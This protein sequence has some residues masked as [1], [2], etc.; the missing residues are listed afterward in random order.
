MNG[1]QSDSKQHVVLI[2]EDEDSN[3]KYLEIV[4]KKAM[5]KVLRAN[6]GI[7]AVEKCRTHPE[8]DILLLDL[9][10]P[11]MDG[12]EAAKR[13]RNILPHLPVIALSAYVSS[14]D[15]EAAM[16]AGCTEYV[17]KPISKTRLLETIT[18]LLRK[19]N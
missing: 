4:L 13:I 9:K 10:M 16:Q 11:G 3:F 15:E 8:I 7:E 19:G 12:F 2:A 14:R 18:R 1:L 6:D 17:V 5:Y